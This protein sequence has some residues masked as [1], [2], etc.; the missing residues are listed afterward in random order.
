MFVTM[1]LGV[2]L[3]LNVIAIAYS[4]RMIAI[5]GRQ[6]AWIFLSIG[7][8]SM[9]LRRLLSFIYLIADGKWHTL[10][11]GYEI[12]GLAGSAIMLAGVI[13][14]KPVFL[15]IKR[16]EEALR[17][18]E[19]NLKRAQEVANVGSWYLD[20]IKNELIWSDQTYHIFKVPV[21]TPLRYERF[22]ETVHPEDRAYVDEAWTAALNRVPYTIEHSILADGETKWV[23][24]KAEVEFDAEGKAVKGL[25]IVQDVTEIKQAEEFAKG[26]LDIIDEAF[27]VIDR[28]YTIVS[29][30]RAYLKQ[31]GM[32]LENIVGTKCYKCSHHLSSPCYEMGEDC[33]VKHTFM[34]GQPHTA[35]HTHLDKEDNNVYVETK[36]YPLKDSSGNTVS[37]IEIIIDVTEKR[38]LEEQLRQS[39]KLEAIGQLAG[40]IAHDFNNM[41]TAIIGYGSLLSNNIEK[42]SPLKPFVDHILSSAEKSANLTGQLLAFSRKQVISPRQ[43]DLNGLIRGMDRLLQRVIGEDIELQLTLSGK[44]LFV[45][46][47]PGQLEQVFINLIT[48]ARDAMPNGGLLSI[49]TEKV[50]LDE[51]YG[52]THDIEKMGMYALVSITDTGVGMDEKTRQRIFEPFFTTKELGK[53][54]GL[55]LSI[56]YGIVKQH[57]GNV[58]VYSEPGKGTTFKIY[59]PL[60]KLSVSQE[61]IAE[62]VIPKGGTETILVAEDNEDVRLLT[63]KVLES[64]GYNVIEAVDG[65]D[66]VKKVEDNKDHIQLAILDVIMPRKSGK[67]A[68]D[69]MKKI[70]PDIRTLFISG[71]TADIIHQRGIL[72]EKTDFLS[73]P[74]SPHELL[75]KIREILDR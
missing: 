17:E 40:G 24:A 54:T 50:K 61:T 2:S 68:G 48:N 18:S 39:Q 37:A 57:N 3:L 58:T 7:I 15:S 5:T 75:A 47:D 66:A 67:E 19:A 11:P 38:K 16:S 70:K 31:V 52:K 71:Y 59:L 33:S 64:F 62:A 27:V 4:L 41:L 34:T 45:M 30:N 60:I 43:V 8:A 13:L 51:S 6:K 20:I 9:G 29:A 74:V 73:K 32:T 65:A 53:G 42:D 49:S 12:V 55:G 14:I 28:E 56:V 1:V 69:E 63:K 36:S 23:R 21:G 25:G 26:I 10:D 44:D 72:E 22:L 46:V 35:L